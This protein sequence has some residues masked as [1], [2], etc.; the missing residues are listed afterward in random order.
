MA[1]AETQLTFGLLA[2]AVGLAGYAAGNQTAGQQAG[3]FLQAAGQNISGYQAAQHAADTG[4]AAPVGVNQGAAATEPKQN[5]AGT[6]G[7]MGVG[8]GWIVGGAA[9]LAAVVVGV[10]G[11]KP[12]KR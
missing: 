4:Q 8:W 1:A 7:I 10:L 3:T 2:A 5:T 12:W 9:V 6:G 11:W